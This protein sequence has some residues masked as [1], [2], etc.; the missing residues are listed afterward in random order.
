LTHETTLVATI[1]IGPAVAFIFGFAAARAGLP[2][3][4]GY[5]GVAPEQAEASAQA[6]GSTTP[7]T[8]VEGM[9]LQSGSIPW[10]IAAGRPWFGEGS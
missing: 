6:I 3:L 9:V 4:V 2:P 1:A 5:L 8:V 7:A 10:P